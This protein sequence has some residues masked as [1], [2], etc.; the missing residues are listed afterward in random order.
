MALI[1]LTDISLSFSGNHLFSNVS[2]SIHKQEKI[3]IVGRNGSGKSTLLQLIQ[4][5]LEPDDGQIKKAQLISIAE[6]EQKLPD[7]PEIRCGEYI[8][9]GLGKLGV[10]IREYFAL[11]EEPEADSDSWAER[12]GKLQ[13]EI[14]HQ[15]GWDLVNRIQQIFNSFNVNENTLVNELSG[16]QIRRMA[17]LKAL[18]RQ[19][20][21]LVLDEPTNHLDIDSIEWL[22]KQIADYQ[23]TVI[24]ISHDR[25]FTAKLATKVWDLDRTVLTVYDCGFNDYLQRKQ[26]ALEREEVEQEK[27]NKLLAQEEAWIRQGVKA[28][29]TRDMGRV[30]R[31]LEMRKQK[32]QFIKQL[33]SAK[34]DIK[35]GEIS[36]KLV[37]ELKNIDFFL[38]ENCIAKDFSALVTRGDR[39]GLVGPNGVG[40][41]SIIRCLTESLPIDS[42][43]RKT[44][45]NIIPAYYRQHAFFED[46][47]KTP[48][49]IVA[50]GQQELEVDGRKKHVIS[51]L[52]EFLF[53]PQR[54]RTPV[55][56][57]SG[58]ERNRL[59]LARVFLKPSNL[60]ILDE[61]TNDLDVE[62]LEVLEDKLSQYGGTVLVVSHD[63]E[64]L[65][66]V[67]TSVWFFQGEGNIIQCV[68][69]YSDLKDQLAES[70]EATSS[71]QAAAMPE[72]VA[73]KG[74]KKGST[75]LSYKLQRELDAMPEQLN[76]AE[77]AIERL[78]SIIGQADFYTQDNDEV[79]RVLS[80]LETAEQHLEQLM[81]RWEELEM[82]KEQSASC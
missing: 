48:S 80:G 51:Y 13:S 6:V 18:A 20:D 74:E 54:C 57:L 53:S 17:I 73:K 7:D 50:D 2:A 19:P 38:G 78:E 15:D 60:L 22:E 69:G 65:D 62:T 4:G 45:T 42:G 61:P 5:K 59:Q 35:Q 72:P 33:G 43:K 32:A 37:Y 56:L 36:G 71:I 81:A 55:R 49:D 46:E 21:I 25:A 28:R 24:F 3:A 66:N 40:K 31:L 58:G 63:R 23:G 75:K 10:V 70:L 41:T 27:F 12:L 11:L 1:N 68:G 77:N 26:E 9:S 34:F 14:E 76:E 29:R 52:G 44:G 67:V 8:L 30:G 39:I 16:G 79:Q 82:L 64:F 47:N